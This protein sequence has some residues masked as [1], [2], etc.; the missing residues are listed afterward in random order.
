MRLKS[1]L[2]TAALLTTS[3]VLRADTINVLTL[4]GSTS[5]G[6]LSGTVTLNATTGKFTAS[7]INFLYTA[8]SIGG[9]TT[10]TTYNFAGAAFN[11]TTGTG[12]SSNDFAGTGAA[13]GYDF[14]LILPTTSLV[15]YI[16]GTLCATTKTCNS[17]VSAIE[18]TATGTD[19][20]Q[21]TSGAL[22]LTSTTTPAVAVTPEPSSLLLLGTGVLG[23]GTM[24]R[25]RFAAE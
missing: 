1:I 9:I 2:V 13:T 5:S 24:L 25:K 12:Y 18:V 15:G 22:T 11:S 19:Y 3:A 4:S 20:S 10:G 8:A 23:V 16:G 14:D 21:V 7:N 6:T 17:Q